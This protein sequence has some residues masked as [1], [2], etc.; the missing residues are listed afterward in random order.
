MRLKRVNKKLVGRTNESQVYIA[1]LSFEVLR[2]EEE[3]LI[4]VKDDGGS[5]YVIYV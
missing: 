3:F 1:S 5:R 2:V 4:K